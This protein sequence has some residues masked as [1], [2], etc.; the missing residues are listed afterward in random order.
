MEQQDQLLGTGSGLG[1]GKGHLL[2]LGFILCWLCG[3]GSVSQFC[4]LS[5]SLLPGKYHLPPRMA[6]RIHQQISLESLL[7]RTPHTKEE[8]LFYLQLGKRALMFPHYCEGPLMFPSQCED[9]AAGKVP[10]GGTSDS[11]HA[12]C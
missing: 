7:E 10:P 2:S 11:L 6:V 5:L 8:W 4:S 1:Q 12:S 3:P 9:D